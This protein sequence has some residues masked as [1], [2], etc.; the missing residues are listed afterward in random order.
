MYDFVLKY[1]FFPTRQ[2][3]SWKL[4]PKGA[5]EVPAQEPVVRPADD[6]PPDA[7]RPFYV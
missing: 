2:P 6:R 1:S 7:E 4:P 5:H 3:A